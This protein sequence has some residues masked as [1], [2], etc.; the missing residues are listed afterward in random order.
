VEYN[1]QKIQ[2]TLHEIIAEISVINGKENT[3]EVNQQN[4]EEIKK[5]QEFYNQHIYILEK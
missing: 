2:G 3:A 1:G 5:S 4:A